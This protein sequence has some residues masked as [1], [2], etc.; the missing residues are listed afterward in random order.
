MEIKA[1]SMKYSKGR[2]IN[3]QIINESIDRGN[4]S[5]SD[6]KTVSETYARLLGWNA[7]IC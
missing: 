3:N 4:T 7:N 6:I 2:V 1:N 5:G